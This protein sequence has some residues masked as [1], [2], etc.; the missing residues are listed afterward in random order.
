MRTIYIL[1]TPDSVVSIIHVMAVPLSEALNR[2][3]VT[4]HIYIIYMYIINV[5][6]T[7]IYVYIYMHLNDPKAY[8]YS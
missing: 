2:L 5:H 4:T 3:C 6:C 1:H 7:C 8:L